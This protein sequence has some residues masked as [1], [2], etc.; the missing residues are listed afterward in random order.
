[1]AII[2][3]TISSC[4][5]KITAGEKRLARLLEGGLSEQCTCW[6]DTRMGDK[7]DHPDFVILAPEKGLLFI[8][9][10]DWFITKIKSANKTHIDYETKNGIEP[11]KNPLEQVR[12]Y[13]FHIINSLKKDP[14]LRQQQGDHEGGFIMPYGY[15]VYLSNIT[16]AQLEKSFIPEELNE[17]LPASQVICKDELN[18]F[19][20]REQI[21]GRLE[22]LLKHRFVHHTTPQ[23]FDRIRWH[24]YPDVRINPSVTRVDLDNFYV[25]HPRCGLHDGQI[26]GT[27]RPKYGGRTQGNSRRS[28]IRQNAHSV[29]PLH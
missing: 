14:L 22:S 19:M 9:V 23:Q 21:S 29:S 15:G 1:M 4:S 3:P 11:L 17:I 7:D 8:E 10:K 26:P 27:A 28:R 2:I 13:T 18:E 16:R 20:T 6:Y 12:Q 25:P 24:L 5:E